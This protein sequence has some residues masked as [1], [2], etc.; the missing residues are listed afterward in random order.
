MHAIHRPF[1]RPAV[2]AVLAVLAVHAPP[3]GT[4]ALASDAGDAFDV[5][6]HPGRVQISLGDVEVAT[7]IYQDDEILRPF[8][9]NVRTSSGI[10]ATRPHPPL[11]GVDAT[12]HAAM[13]PGIWLAFGDIS[14]EDFWRNRGRIEHVRFTEPPH[15]SQGQ[16]TFATESRLLAAKDTARSDAELGRMESYILLRPIRGGWLLDWQATFRAN[17][18]PLVFGDQEEM[19]FGA[20]VATPL[21]EQRGG[22]LTSSSGRTSA[23]ET[24]GQPAAWCDYAGT[25]SGTQ[26]GITLIASSEN[27]RTSWW[28]NRDYG[29]FVAN[30]FGRAAMKQGGASRIEVPPAR[31]L[32]LR[33]AAVIHEGD[34]YDAATVAA[35]VFAGDQERAR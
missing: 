13:H 2:V 4:H 10:P 28:H 16:L 11:E 29:V 31:P 18:E 24:W 26:V 7:Y 21:T 30:P 23:A 35:E 3:F 8:F 32:V 34:R 27:F 9:A 5:V 6:E 19:G 1:P 25:V 17:G 14:G 22:T 33:F 20:R 12:D 15:V